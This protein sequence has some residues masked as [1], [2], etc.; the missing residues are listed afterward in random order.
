[1]PLTPAERAANMKRGREAAALRKAAGP[2]VVD[3]PPSTAS[4]PLQTILAAIQDLGARVAAIESKPAAVPN[5]PR[6]VPM[7]RSDPT[8]PR[9]TQFDDGTTLRE[10]DKHLPVGTNGQVIP[11]QAMR[12]FRKRFDQ[13]S[14]VTINR[15]AERPGAGRLVSEEIVQQ[16]NG[17]VRKVKREIVP[18][19]WG[20]VLDELGSYVCRRMVH[21][22]QCGA[23]VAIGDRC[24]ACGD[25]PRVRKALWLSRYGEWKYK[26]VVPGLTEG[27]MGDGFYDSELLAG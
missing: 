8:G 21:D 15:A 4:D 27:K 14:L 9:I 10:I 2:K 20:E 3:A 23:R 13:G 17:K 16:V 24:A 12:M 7:E 18:I 25:G 5:V 11:D 26:V 19:T 22:A 6:F 1:M